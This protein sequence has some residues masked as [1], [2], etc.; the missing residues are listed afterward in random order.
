MKPFLDDNFLLES[1]CAIDL[2]HGYAKDEPVIDFHCHLSPEQIAT[3]HR[4]RSITELWLDGDHYKWRAMRANGVAERF[5]A[6]DAS[7]WEKFEAW[8]GTVPDAIR[9]PLYHWTHMELRRPF[10]IDALLS[11][12]TARDV[13]TRCNER[14]SE[15]GF[16]TLGL[17]R[18]FRVAVVCT[19]DDPV[20]SL[21]HHRTLAARPDP[22]T[23][24][25]PGGQTRRWRSRIPMRSMPGSRGSSR[26]RACRS[27]EA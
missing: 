18:D 10:G 25:Y 23:R 2:Y 12:A 6:G 7:D 14:L 9:S 21:A 8:A 26:H 27:A 24:V 19:T 15:D 4:F 22:D 20:D 17:L 16:T 13:F 1:E 11:P 5:C 3:N